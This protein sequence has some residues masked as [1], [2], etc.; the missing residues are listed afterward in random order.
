MNFAAALTR[1]EVDALSD[2]DRTY[3][4]A[5]NA[6]EH[7]PAS[8][9]EHPGDTVF[10]KS[11]RIKNTLDEYEE[12]ARKEPSWNVLAVLTNSEYRLWCLNAETPMRHNPFLTHWVEASQRLDK[13]SAEGKLNTNTFSTPNGGITTADILEVRV[14]WIK[15]LLPNKDVKEFLHSTPRELHDAFVKRGLKK[16]FNIQTYIQMLEEEGIYD[17]TPEPKV[18]TWT[19]MQEHPRDNA[20]KQWKSDMLQKLKEQPDTAVQELTHLPLELSYLDFLTTLLTD[21]TLQSLSIDPAPVITTY[22]QHSLRLA[23]QM[24]GPPTDATV[25]GHTDG[26]LDR[27]SI[28]EYGKEAQSRAV[29]LLLLFIK[30]LIRKELLG[31]EVLYFEIQEIC[32][33]YVWIKEVRDFRSWVEEGIGE[34]HV[35]ES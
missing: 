9:D 16:A 14:E 27:S 11:L 12:N 13:E 4:D 19:R 6:L 22:I 20:S 34:E 26:P 30:S 23:E 17:K 25:D 18:A 24:A 10:E 32:V 2:P 33:R 31:T 3:S 5:A 7:I 29:R 21:R 35:R 1:P 15:R 8:A 28:W